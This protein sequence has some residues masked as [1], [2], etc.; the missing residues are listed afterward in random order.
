M[1]LKCKARVPLSESPSP[2]WLAKFR[3]AMRA[4]PGTAGATVALVDG[5]IVFACAG[6]DIESVVAD[7]DRWIDVANGDKVRGIVM[8]AE[9]ETHRELSWRERRAISDAVERAE[10]LSEE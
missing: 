3:S 10:S 6:G 4:K 1:I 8:R 7:I 9:G 5:D 2:D